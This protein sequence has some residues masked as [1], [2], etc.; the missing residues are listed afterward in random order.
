MKMQLVIVVL[1]PE[2]KPSYS[3]KH[4]ITCLFA[5]IDIVLLFI[6][7]NRQSYEYNSIRRKASM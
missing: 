2:G 4:K 3:E 1:I 6:N 7:Q 5:L